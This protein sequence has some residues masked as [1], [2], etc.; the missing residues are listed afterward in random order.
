MST[1]KQEGADLAAYSERFLTVWFAEG[2][3]PAADPEILPD[4]KPGTVSETLVVALV[5]SNDVA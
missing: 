5:G 4:A 1:V 2:P 3:G